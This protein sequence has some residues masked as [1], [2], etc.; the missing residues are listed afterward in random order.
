M[1]STQLVRAVIP[2]LDLMIGQVVLA[3]AGNRDEYRPIE[4][5]LTF[6]SRPLEVAKAIFNQTCCDWLYLADIDSFAGASP[7]WNVYNELLNYGFGLWIDANWMVDDRFE[8]IHE[9]IQFPKRLEI[10]LSSETLTSLD[11]FSILSQ[12][13]GKGIQ[14]I[15]SLDRKSGQTI[16]QPGE[17]SELAP[18]EL[19]QEAYK[20]GVRSL[21]VLDLDSVGT[22]KGVASKDV[23]VG[24]LIQEIK[25]KLGDMRIISGGGIREADDVKALLE[26]GC[27]HVLVASAIHELKLTPDDIMEFPVSSFDADADSVSN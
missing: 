1:S 25:S 27:Q 5:P 8:Q 19:A 7:N 18:I 21:I 12:L 2:V 9:K 4:T 6:S 22:M 10:I 20:H 23:G 15:F 16:T 26:A 11:Q 13:I 24:P 17:L 14:P 3:K